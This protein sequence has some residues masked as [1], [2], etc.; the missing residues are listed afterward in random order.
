MRGLGLILLVMAMPVA[1]QPSADDVR[2]Q[3]MMMGGPILDAPELEKRLAAAADKPLGSRENPVRVSGA[4]AEYAY[5]GRLRCNDG[6]PPTFER[7]GSF[8][9]GPFDSILDR[10]RFDCRSA[11]PAPQPIFIDMYHPDHIETNAVPG[12]TITP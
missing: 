10:Y 4:R 11:G 3:R 8:G 7:E 5:M 2:L 1:A 12:F 6:Q 9:A